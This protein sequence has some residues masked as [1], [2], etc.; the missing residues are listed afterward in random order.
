MR[1]TMS[2]HRAPRA[3]ATSGSSRRIV[4]DC[5]AQDGAEDCCAVDCATH[6]VALVEDCCAEV[7]TE[8]EECVEERERAAMH[9]EEERAEEKERAE[10]KQSER[11]HWRSERTAPVTLGRA[12]ARS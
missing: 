4:E 5:C 2:P 1:S 7:R 9:A 3:K 8:E 11:T 12:V 10:K 6:G